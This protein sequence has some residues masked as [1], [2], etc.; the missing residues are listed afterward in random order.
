[1]G[2]KTALAVRRDHV[3][4]RVDAVEKELLT[5]QADDLLRA[6][7]FPRMLCYREVGFVGIFSTSSVR[8]ATA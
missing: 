1:V 7:K 4:E 8:F 6:P 3:A 5:I 2:A